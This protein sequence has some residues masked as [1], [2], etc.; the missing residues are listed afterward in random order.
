MRWID[1]MGS[2]SHLYREKQDALFSFCLQKK[3]QKIIFF[4]F[5]LFV[6]AFCCRQAVRSPFWGCDA[7]EYFNSYDDAMSEANKLA[8][9]TEEVAGGA[10]E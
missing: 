6:A 5:L 7:P 9:I 10:N 3:T 2:F 1:L 8:G 4:L